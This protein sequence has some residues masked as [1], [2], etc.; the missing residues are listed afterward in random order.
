VII[1]LEFA[2][3]AMGLCETRHVLNSKQ[4][5]RRTSN[6]QHRMLNMGDAALDRF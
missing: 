1:E 2:G 3:F 5:E 6:V 4:I